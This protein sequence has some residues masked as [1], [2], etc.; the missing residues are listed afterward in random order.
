MSR[1][2]AP[3]ILNFRKDGGEWSTSGSDRFTP[4]KERRYPLNGRVVVPCGA[5]LDV[6]KNRK[7]SPSAEIRT[8]YRPA[9]GLF[10]IFTTLSLLS[11][12]LYMYIKLKIM[13]KK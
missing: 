13:L 5:K 10:A 2:M 8:P 1:G 12:S 11:L 3:P 4:G 7:I 6:L 9:R